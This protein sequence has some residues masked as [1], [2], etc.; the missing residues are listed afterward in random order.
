MTR[1][2][3]TAIGN[4]TKGLLSVLV[5]FAARAPA[6]TLS[7]DYNGDWKVDAADYALLR[8]SGADYSAWRTNYGYTAANMGV[9]IPAGA[10]IQTAIN[11]N[12]AGTIFYVAAGERRFA[13]P[14]APKN[15]DAFVAAPGAVLNGSRLLTSF[16]AASG[17]WYATGQTQQ[18]STHGECLVGYSQC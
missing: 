6:A 3:A 5:F 7:G 16:T 15:G 9:T 1:H 14:L 18:G 8:K 2:E 17:Q 4:M 11:N 10:D 13:A 12:P